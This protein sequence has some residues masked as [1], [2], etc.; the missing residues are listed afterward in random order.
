MRRRGE[1]E[2][3]CKR[4][5]REGGVGCGEVRHSRGEFYRCRGG[6]GQSDGEGNRVISGGAP[7]W[8]IRFGGEGKQRG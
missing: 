1:G 2:L 3:W 8:A 5:G 4:G 6:A 7:L